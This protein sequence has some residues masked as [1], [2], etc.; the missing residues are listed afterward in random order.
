[1]KLNENVVVLVVQWVVAATV[2]AYW[3]WSV[4]K[5]NT[6]EVERK[7]RLSLLRWEKKIKEIGVRGTKAKTWSAIRRTTNKEN[8]FEIHRCS[9]D[10]GFAIIA[11]LI[12]VTAHRHLTQSHIWMMVKLFFS[13]CFLVS[14]HSDKATLVLEHGLEPSSP[15]SL[16][17]ICSN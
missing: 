13:I 4:C 15:L 11:T 9:C 8:A 12:C 6:P 2:V 10:L 14:Y 3:Q 1:M 17:S 5:F 7:S 16:N